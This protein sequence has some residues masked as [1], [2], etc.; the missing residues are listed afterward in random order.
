[1]KNFLASLLGKQKPTRI[2]D[3]HDPILG[4]L[5]Y[6]DEGSWEATVPIGTS[7]IYF[8]IGGEFKPDRDLIDHAHKIIVNFDVFSQTI[9]EFLRSEA[10]RFPE[11]ATEEINQLQI[12]EI[13]L[14]WPGRPDDGIIFF[15]GPD[16]TRLWRCDYIQRMP[17]N[18]GFD[19]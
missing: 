14:S 1:M 4:P 19:W 13:S 12:E 11:A 10:K 2:K 6:S 18:L 8:V 5:I 7:K 9:G 3:R 17:R 15:S 16:E